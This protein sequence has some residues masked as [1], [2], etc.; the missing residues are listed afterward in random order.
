MSKEIDKL[1]KDH[2]KENSYLDFDI[3]EIGIGYYSLLKNPDKLINFSCK[4]SSG[5]YGEKYLEVDNSK[6]EDI[7][8]NIN[9]LEANDKTKY[10]SNCSY[11]SSD[12]SLYINIFVKSQTHNLIEENLAR[13]I[14]PK[15]M[16]I[17][18][19]GLEMSDLP[20]GGYVW[21]DY[22]EGQNL[23]IKDFSL[24][25]ELLNKEISTENDK[26]HVFW[27]KLFLQIEKIN[28]SLIISG[29]I[30]LIIFFKLLDLK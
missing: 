10:I 4:F 24:H 23:P 3:F 2:R 1:K 26:H 13:K 14:F 9:L 5:T 7:H 29:I 22:K 12:N 30:L 11:V 16:R 19:T 8:L 21:A 18:V 15:S 25:Y 17:I 28:Y 20:D 6:V 27:E